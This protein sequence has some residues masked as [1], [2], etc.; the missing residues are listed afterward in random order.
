MVLAM[1]AQG[2]VHSLGLFERIQDIRDTVAIN[3]EGIPSEC[4]EFIPVR[5]KGVLMHGRL[6]LAKS[7][8]VNQHAEVIEL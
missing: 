2:F 6:R 5:F 4:P 8:H 3:H 1:I 7:V